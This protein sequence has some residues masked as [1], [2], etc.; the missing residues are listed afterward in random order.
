MKQRELNA[1]DTVAAAARAAAR[2]EGYDVGAIETALVESRLA[3]TD[4][5]AAVAL[6]GKRATWLRDF[7]K[8]AT[9]NN[10]LTKAEAAIAA[11]QAK[12]EEM[13]IAFL[14]RVEAIDSEAAAA[15]TAKTAGDNA[16]GH[17]LDPKNVPGTIGEKYREAVAAAE[18]ADLAV[19]DLRRQ[20][21]DTL[22]RAKSE[23]GWIEQLTGDPEKTLATYSPLIP[24][25]VTADTYKVQDHRNALARAE[26]RKTEIEGQLVEAEKTAARARKAVDALIP[27]VVKA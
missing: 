19:E 8:L 17:L 7:E 15:R 5:E 23:Q 16:R 4:F 21:R 14:Q 27:D 6:A 22:A 12:F 2:G 26:R 13:R 3:M 24:K 18:A 9:S 10:K 20:L 11:E 1:I 25:N